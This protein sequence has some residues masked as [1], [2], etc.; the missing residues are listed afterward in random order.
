[1]EAQIHGNDRSQEEESL[2]PFKISSPKIDLQS[3]HRDTM[4]GFLADARWRAGIEDAAK[5][6]V[7]SNLAIALTNQVMTNPLQIVTR[8]L[9]F[10]LQAKRFVPLGRDCVNTFWMVSI[11]IQ[12][13][14]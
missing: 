8:L 11:E 13:T 4:V 2:D 3:R 10:F 9:Q 5:Q 6:A 7:S 12:S 14:S 1:M